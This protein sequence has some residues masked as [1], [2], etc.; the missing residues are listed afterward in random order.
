LLGSTTKILETLAQDLQE[1]RP[2]ELR[3][4]ERHTWRRKVVE[5][6][7]LE[8][9]VELLILEAVMLDGQ[10]SASCSRRHDRLVERPT[11]ADNKPH[12]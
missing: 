5:G 7:V 4:N 1:E 6:E 10:E 11:A 9:G 2:G 8:L 3:G 12:M